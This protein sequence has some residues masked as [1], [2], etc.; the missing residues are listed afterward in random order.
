[1]Q[2]N[3]LLLLALSIFSTTCFS[4]LETENLS[5]EPEHRQYSVQEI[6]EALN[7]RNYNSED[8]NEM[9]LDAAWR[10]DSQQV[11]ALLDE[12]ANID[13]QSE[14]GSTALHYAAYHDHVEVTALLLD[15]GASTDIKNNLGNTALHDTCFMALHKKKPHYPIEN[16]III[17]KLLTY[18]KANIN[19][20]NSFYETTYYWAVYL[21]INVLEA[22]EALGAQTKN[23]YKNGN[24]IMCKPNFQ[25]SM[26]KFP[27][28]QQDDDENTVR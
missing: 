27:W 18:C 1:M 11:K 13:Y 9:L 4:M 3:K 28:K 7:Q 23:S 16:T 22:L 26:N 21:E 2:T 12:G 5:P 15:L 20:M 17:I 10:G 8:L 6:S 25:F 24:I 19:E 14:N